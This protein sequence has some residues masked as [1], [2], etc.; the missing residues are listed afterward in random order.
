MT[1]RIA[2]AVCQNHAGLFCPV[3]T[4]HLINENDIVSSNIC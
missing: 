4:P 3:W 2:V 1:K